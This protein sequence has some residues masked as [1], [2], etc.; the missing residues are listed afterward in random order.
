M[1]KEKDMIVKEAMEQPP[2]SG[3]GSAK[4]TG[5]PGEKGGKMAHEI[6]NDKFSKKLVGC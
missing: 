6:T 3:G 1:A 5:V 4:G 2:R